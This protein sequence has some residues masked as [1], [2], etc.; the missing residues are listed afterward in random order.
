[1]ARNDGYSRCLK[2]LGKYK[3]LMTRQ[4]YKSIRGQILA[5]DESS[6]AYVLELAKKQEKR[7]D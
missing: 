6:I 3:G 2:W 4:Q 5:G 7:E 1:M